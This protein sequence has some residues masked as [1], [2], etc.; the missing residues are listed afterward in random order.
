MPVRGSRLKRPENIGRQV[1]RQLGPLLNL[2][3]L[4]EEINNRLYAS[5]R[6]EYFENP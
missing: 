2:V 5:A 1:V 6:A 4:P 3:R